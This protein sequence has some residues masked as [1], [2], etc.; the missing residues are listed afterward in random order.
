MDKAKL[1]V[2]SVLSVCGPKWLSCNS[3]AATYYYV[4]RLE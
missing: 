3:E 2:L 4:D 1:N